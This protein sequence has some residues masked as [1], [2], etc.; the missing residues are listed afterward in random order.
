[1]VVYITAKSWQY[2]IL[3]HRINLLSMKF[4]KGEILFSWG[5][6]ALMETSNTFAQFVLSSLERHKKGDWGNVCPGDQKAN[7]DALIYQSR[8]FSAYLGE[9]KIWIITEWNRSVTTVL[10]PID[11]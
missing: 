11:Y 5:V 9:K 3:K 2:T 4:E 7:D 8:L 6:Y 1:M 10:F